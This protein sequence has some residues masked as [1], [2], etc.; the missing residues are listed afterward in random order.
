M[1]KNSSEQKTDSYDAK[2]HNI[3]A[4]AVREL[5]IGSIKKLAP[6][7][8][9]T[10]PSKII[11]QP[12]SKNARPQVFV[13]KPMVSPQGKKNVE[14]VNIEVKDSRKNKNGEIQVIDLEESQD[15]DKEVSIIENSVNPDINVNNNTRELLNTNNSM[16]KDKVLENDIENELD[17][18]E[19][20]LNE[21]NN[22]S[23]TNH[24]LNTE[25]D[26]MLE[27]EIES[28]L[29]NIEKIL[30]EDND[31]NHEQNKED[32][33]LEDDIEREL[34]DIDKMFDDDY[35][36][37]DDQSQEEEEILED[38][39]ENEL[40]N[41]DKM[42]ND[43]YG[44][45]NEL[46]STEEGKMLE[47]DIESELENTEKILNEGNNINR[48]NNKL[49]EEVKTIE[50][51]IESEL[52][53][54]EKLLSEDDKIYN[55]NIE[56]FLKGNMEEDNS[57]QIE[58]N[59]EM[60]NEDTAIDND[61]ND[62]FSELQ[63]GSV[64][65][66]PREIFEDNVQIKK[67]PVEQGLDVLSPQNSPTKNSPS[68][69]KFEGTPDFNA[70][71]VKVELSPT[72][73]NKFLRKGSFE[74]VIVKPVKVVKGRPTKVIQA[75]LPTE[76]LSLNVLKLL[77]CQKSVDVPVKTNI[78]K[79]KIFNNFESELEKVH[80]FLNGSWVEIENFEEVPMKVEDSDGEL[81]QSWCQMTG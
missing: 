69:R 31:T 77:D 80:G 30:N 39:I 7:I 17:N 3:K 4:R 59:S 62:D 81:Y 70:F 53:N 63:I 68:K 50:N 72:S 10:S 57:E 60:S 21:D 29:E 58:T 15:N 65:S 55:E 56:Q 12:K 64:T 79:P 9:T 71:K 8:S 26:K 75:N 48:T 42:L 51:E 66:L 36:T 38:D 41:I 1:P 45:N 34:E 28:E 35:G 5:N 74:K 23:D 61:N 76:C 67:E 40:E 14:M 44:T 13:V 46:S 73:P 18:I 25:E 33:T 24:K 19:K 2:L 6:H 49:S 20:L 47:N 37:N 52:E 22:E 27:N 11:I 16:E 43:D 32:K 54:I 78:V